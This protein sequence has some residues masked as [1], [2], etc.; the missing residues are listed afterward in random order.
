MLDLVKKLSREQFLRDATNIL[1]SFKES[2]LK[3]FNWELLPNALKR[4]LDEMARE[5]AKREKVA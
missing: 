5:K 2:E 1:Y 3:N 4:E